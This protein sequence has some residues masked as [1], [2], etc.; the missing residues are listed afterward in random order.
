MANLRGKSLGVYTQTSEEMHLLMQQAKQQAQ[1]RKHILRRPL[2]DALR[3]PRRMGALMSRLNFSC[4]CSCDCV[5]RRV[6]ALMKSKAALKII[7]MFTLLISDIDVFFLSVSMYEYFNASFWIGLIAVGALAIVYL[8]GV[9]FGAMQRYK[10][11]KHI[12][13][14]CEQ[15]V[16]R[17]PPRLARHCALI[18]PRNVRR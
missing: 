6:D 16:C 5:Y 18:A 11:D 3:N 17:Q 1:R 4:S 15:G 2:L 8:G 13:Q 14:C 9:Y 7:V 12:I 10:L